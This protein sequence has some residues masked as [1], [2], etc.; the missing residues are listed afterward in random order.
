MVCGAQGSC[1]PGAYVVA[2][3]T[4]SQ[5]CAADT[6][7]YTATQVYGCTEGFQFYSCVYASACIGGMTQSNVTRYGTDRAC[8]GWR[9]R[10]AQLLLRAAR[11]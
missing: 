8:G 11:Q 5:S 3:G 4:P 2:R 10:R 1:A 9:R 6:T 7:K